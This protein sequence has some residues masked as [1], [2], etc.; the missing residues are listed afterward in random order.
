MRQDYDLESDYCAPAPT[1]IAKIPMGG[2]TG[3]VVISPYNSRA[4]WPGAT[5]HG[6][7]PP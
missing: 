1:V 4:T 2:R 3:D 6:D 5:R 7:H